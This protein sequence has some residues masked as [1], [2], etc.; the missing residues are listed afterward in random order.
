MSRSCANPLT[1]LYCVEGMR[2]AAAA[3]PRAWRDGRDLSARS[4]MSYAS[5][6]GGLALANAG[7]GA[8][9]G[10]AAPLGGMLAIR[11]YERRGKKRCQDLNHRNRATDSPPLPVRLEQP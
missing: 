9:H 2:L 6:L 10:F 3:L 8:V 1:D 7:L 11:T 4:D 5:L